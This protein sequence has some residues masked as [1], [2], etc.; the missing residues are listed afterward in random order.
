ML[1]ECNNIL[2]L[3]TGTSH[4]TRYV[5]SQ[6]NTV[7]VLYGVFLFTVLLYAGENM[8]IKCIIS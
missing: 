5:P 3:E 8:P 4:G 7:L 1:N 6:T 2:L